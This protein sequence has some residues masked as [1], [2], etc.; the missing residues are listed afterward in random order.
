M[1]HYK[2]VDT[3]YFDTEQNFWC[4]DAW[5]TDDENEEGKVVA[6]IHASGDYFITD[7]EA[8]SCENVQKA[9]SD[10]VR[11]ITVGVLK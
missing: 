10:K 8:R 6:V 9:I 11:E 2:C 4:V 1:V 7:P 3:N 5:R